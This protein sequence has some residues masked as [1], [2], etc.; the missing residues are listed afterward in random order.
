LAAQQQQQ[1]VNHSFVS[2]LK[3]QLEHWASWV[4]M[5]SNNPQQ[6]PP[7]PQLPPQLQAMQASMAQQQQYQQMAQQQFMQ[8]QQQYIQ[9]HPAGYQGGLGMG[10]APQAGAL[11]GFTGPVPAH[12]ALS[13]FTDPWAEKQQ[14]RLMQHRQ[15][16]QDTTAGQHMQGA[17]EPTPW[18]QQGQGQQVQ[19]SEQEQMLQPMAVLSPPPAVS[20]S[21]LMQQRRALQ[22]QAFEG[23]SLEAVLGSAK[24]SKPPSRK[25]LVEGGQQ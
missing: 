20:A 5:H 3:R 21:A 10:A 11:G 14:Q 9:Q 22:Q 4:H 19:A 6:V 2:E 17:P 25:Q 12:G 16:T 1:S 8:Q 23:L 13:R 24:K 7:P 18:Q 15:S